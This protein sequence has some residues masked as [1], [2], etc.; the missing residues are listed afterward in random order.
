MY[1]WYGNAAAQTF[2]RAHRRRPYGFV[3]ADYAQTVGIVWGLRV[4]GYLV[5][6]GLRVNGYF[7]C[8]GLCGKILRSV[9][10]ALPVCPPVSPHKG[11]SVV[12]FPTHNACVFGM[13]T[14]LRGRSGGHTGAAPTQDCSIKGAFVAISVQGWH[15]HL[16][17]KRWFSFLFVSLQAIKM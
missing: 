13:E 2:G 12:K 14:P 8:M 9:V 16:A 15:F 3:W 17:W 7:V 5:C 10:G 11:A 6:V 4:N 1:F